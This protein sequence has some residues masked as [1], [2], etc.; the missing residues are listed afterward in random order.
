MRHH[1]QL[2]SFFFVLL[3]VSSSSAA[4]ANVNIE[5]IQGEGFVRFLIETP[6]KINYGAELNQNELKITFEQEVSG[7]LHLPVVNAPDYF[8]AS[9]NAEVINTLH[10]T[11]AENLDIQTTQ[12]D[13]MIEIDLLQKSVVKTLASILPLSEQRHMIEGSFSKS[14]VVIPQEFE[15]LPVVP[16]MLKHPS[17]HLGVLTVENTKHESAEN[18]YDFEKRLTRSFLNRLRLQHLGNDF[19]TQEVRLLSDFAAAEKSEKKVIALDVVEFYF[20][21]KLFIEAYQ[22]LSSTDVDAKDR[23]FLFLKAVSA[24]SI[25]R[26]DSVLEVLDGPATRRSDIYR[27]MAFAKMGAFQAAGELLFNIDVSGNFLHA[28][29]Y[30]SL[31]AE[32]ALELKNIDVA[33]RILSSAEEMNTQELVF[34]KSRLFAETGAVDKAITSYKNISQSQ[35]L[36]YRLRARNELAYIYALSGDITYQ[37]ALQ[38]IELATLR[39]RE[40]R[41]TRRASYLQARLLKATGDITASI[42]AWRKLYDDYPS[43]DYAIIAANEIRLLLAK[44]PD[45][46]S[47]SPLT[48]AGV[49]YENVDF[50]PPGEEGDALIQRVADDL[51]MLDLLAE[52]AELIEHQTFKRSRGA[53]MAERAMRLADVYLMNKQPSEALR[54]LR[55]TRFARLPEGVQHRRTLLEATALYDLEQFEASL[56]VLENQDSQNGELLRAEIYWRM[57]DWVNAGNSFELSGLWK[58]AETQER[59]LNRDESIAVLRAVSAYIRAGDDEKLHMLHKKASTNLFNVEANHLLDQIATPEHDSSV[60]MLI[61]NYVEL[62][63][64]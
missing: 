56:V 37:K 32:T 43:A 62:F 51:V 61:D 34:L 12:L 1:C 45:D 20:S 42:N 48:V 52:A 36:E 28:A 4:P 38:D 44:M 64:V 31:K 10:Y 29:D 39:W 54:V 17:R 21:N 30:T 49:F 40:A 27:G 57:A 59:M 25:G 13:N 22:F 14:Y 9:H 6:E 63:R 58:S 11:V 8:Y 55:T 35:N 3:W 60:G 5:V 15:S 24:Y 50:S 41:L 18:D 16:E 47:L 53:K 19:I 7:D 26:Y 33:S 23:D 46:K 2:I